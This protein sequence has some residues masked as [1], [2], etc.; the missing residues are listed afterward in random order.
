MVIEVETML[1]T[2]IRKRCI[3]TSETIYP[4]A[5]KTLKKQGEH[6]LLKE[7]LDINC[8]V[9]EEK[10]DNSQ[11]NLQKLQVIYIRMR[12]FRRPVRLDQFQI[13]ECSVGLE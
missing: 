13:D 2:W 12:S 7:F 1:P 4:N 10:E 3:A 8:G 6:N 11:S 5:N 9:S